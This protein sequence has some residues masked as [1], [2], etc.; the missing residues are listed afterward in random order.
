MIGDNDNINVL[1]RLTTIYINKILCKTI[2]IYI[3]RYIIIS[4][5]HHRYHNDKSRQI[6]CIRHWE[7]TKVIGQSAA[8]FRVRSLQVI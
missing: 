6:L 8:D 3:Y 5:S 1:V 4:I 7:C 2:Y